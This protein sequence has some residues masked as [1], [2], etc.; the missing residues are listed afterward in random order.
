MMRLVKDVRNALQTSQIVV[1]IGA[2]GTGKRACA[3]TLHEEWRHLGLTVL[4]IDAASA[5]YPEDL[6]APLATAIN[7]EPTSLSASG[8]A[9]NQVVR[10][11]LENC[12]EL[13][14]RRWVADWQARW[15]ALFTSKE[16]QGRLAAI[17]FGAPLFRQIAGGD[18]S[19]LLNAGRVITVSPLTAREIEGLH[20][21]EPRRADAVHRK[22]GGHPEITEALAG[23]L[24]QRAGDMRKAVGLV[25]DERRSFV[26]RLVQDH[27]LGA[28]AVLGDLLRES[29]AIHES[30]LI[31]KHFEGAP[32]DGADAL[33]D[34]CGCGLV[35]RTEGNDCMIGAD[36]LRNIDGLR[37]VISAPTMTVPRYEAAVMDAAWRCLFLAEN[38]LREVIAENLQAMEAAWWILHVPSEMRAAAE[39]RKKNEISIASVDEDQSHPLMYLT[40]GELFGLV[41]SNWKRVF[42]TVFSP[43]TLVAVEDAAGH[44]EAIR[45]RLAHSRPV[46]EA[47][48]AELGLLARRLRLV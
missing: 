2:R 41:S 43:L 6:N 4:R 23:A 40:V 21:L 24:Q 36:L 9:E 3:D 28:Q 29:S 44:F 32:A 37:E 5:K 18:A 26:V 7:S 14:D 25:C 34:L 1:V 35:S 38:R 27:P 20:G 39:G 42:R 12:D 15:R 30:A 19:P 46:S 10:V 45:N 17:L 22:A 16:A 33:D 47:Q 8:L 13:Y 31:R 11:I 48:V